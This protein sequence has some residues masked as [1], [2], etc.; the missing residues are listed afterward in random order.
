MNI[1]ITNHAVERYRERVPGSQKLSDDAIRMLIR[2]I[3]EPAFDNG[4]VQDHPGYP[5][6]RLVWFTVGKDSL[7]FA[8]GPNDT[9]YP[10]EWAVIGTLHDR[11]TG[12][13]GSGATIGDVVPESVKQAVAEAAGKPQKPRYLLRIRR[14]PKEAGEVYDVKDDEELGDLL[15]RRRPDPDQV[16]VFERKAFTIRQIYTIERPKP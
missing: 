6:R 8:L 2:D 13:T 15:N 9:K 16:E 3:V 14:S 11:E 5:E 4:L 7:C 1:A 12:K 10:G